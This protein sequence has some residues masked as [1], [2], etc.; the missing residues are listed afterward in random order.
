M[1]VKAV[2]MDNLRGLLGIMK[3]NKVPNAWIKQ[4]C[5]VIKRCSKGL[6]KVFFDVSSMCRE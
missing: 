1:A 4:F 3:I 5:G 6:I 2:Q